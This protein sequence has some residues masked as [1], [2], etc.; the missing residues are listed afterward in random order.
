MLAARPLLQFP[1]L[2]SPAGSLP[3]AAPA[4][5]GNELR[6]AVILPTLDEAA[7]IAS[8]V[9]RARLEADE[10]VVSDGGS[11]DATRSLAV[12]SGAVVVLSPPGRGA[13]LRCG[14]EHSS[15]EIL[16]FLHADTLLPP[17]A[18]PL[19]RRAIERGAVGGGF[20]MRWDDPGLLFR[21]GERWINLRTRLTAAPL[22]DQA[23]FATRHAYEAAGG[24]PDWPLLEDLR[25][26][27]RLRRQGRLAMLR[28]PVVSSARRF[29]RLGI[30]RALAI[31]WTIFALYALG[32]SPHRLARLYPP[33]PPRR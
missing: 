29:R 23:Q 32:I 15:A 5:S 25:F 20:A 27:R 17:G 11:R 4:S 13:Q 6:L 18:G 31:N 9:A 24:F 12:E 21:V 10:V 14:V 33:S 26:I 19:V 22:G 7:T 28:P 1:P 3:S 30:A 8:V 16:L 2:Q